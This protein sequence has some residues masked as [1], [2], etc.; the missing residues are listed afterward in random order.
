MSKKFYHHLIEYHETISILDS[1]H[2]AKEEMAELADL[3]DQIFHHHLLNLILTHLPSSHHRDFISRL[4]K[5]PADPHLLVYLKE[6]IT[7]VDIETEI[8]KHGA[9][10]KADILK[11]IHKS[12][13]SH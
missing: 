9:K 10:I 2:L 7:V 4:T 1:H 6:K 8:K 5:N 11:D 12:K 13:S 3:I